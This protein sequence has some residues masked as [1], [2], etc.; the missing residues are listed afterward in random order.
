MF[1]V[2]PSKS[3]PVA[4]SDLTALPVTNSPHYRMAAFSHVCI[5]TLRTATGVSRVQTWSEEALRA[6]IVPLQAV[7]P[8]IWM[9]AVHS[10]FH[11]AS[12]RVS[13]TS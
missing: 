2:P 10:E 5:F 8:Y 7:V 11:S 3:L 9:R 13:G 1:L 12:D 6:D 4:L